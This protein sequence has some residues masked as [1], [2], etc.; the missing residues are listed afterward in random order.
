MCVAAGAAKDLVSVQPDLQQLLAV[1]PFLEAG[2]NLVIN[3]DSKSTEHCE[4]ASNGFS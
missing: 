1:L 3:G 4:C 2:R